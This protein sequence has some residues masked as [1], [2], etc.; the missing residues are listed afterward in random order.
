MSDE[1]NTDSANT[2]SL[3][4]S[5][6]VADASTTTTTTTT[7]ETTTE[8]TPGDTT[9]KSL[10]FPDDGKTE[11]NSADD[12]GDVK[13]DDT[14]KNSDDDTDGD[15]EK[16]EGLIEYG[17][18][19]QPAVPINDDALAHFLPVFKGLELSQEQVQATINAMG[20]F[21]KAAEDAAIANEEAMV[22]EFQKDPEHTQLTT[23]AKRLLVQHASESEMALFS[24][25]S[26]GNNPDVIRFL[27]KVQGLVREDSVPGD[28]NK[29]GGVVTGP[30]ALYG[31]VD[32]Q[33][34]T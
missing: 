6:E 19:E 7:A 17:E 14:E 3:L 31:K 16:E 8:A 25:P 11:K 18:F 29:P 20:D 24:H 30:A 34:P 23:S 21:T 5:A 22:K 15:T 2:D 9:A 13:G 26:V 4:G 32:K 10:L 33:V 27:A 12:A 1:V 28:S